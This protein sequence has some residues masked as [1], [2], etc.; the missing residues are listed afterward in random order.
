MLKVTFFN[1]GSQNC[2]IP[3]PIFNTFTMF[4]GLTDTISRWES[5]SKSN[6]EVKPP[7]ISNHSIFQKHRWMKNS[8][9]RLIFAGSCFKQ[10]NIMLT[11]RNVVNLYIAYELD[12][13]WQ[14]LNAEFTL[15]DCLF[16]ACKLTKNADPDKYSYS[17]YSIGFYSYSFFTLQNDSS[18]NVAIFWSRQ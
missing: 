18:E 7:I 4:S 12:A 10:G 1:D 9:T 3:Q 14:D 16:W 8:K 5:N 11:P 15:K 13:W 6:K 2:S 17:G